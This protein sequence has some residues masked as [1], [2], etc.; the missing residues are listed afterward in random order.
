M[1]ADSKETIDEL[2]DVAERLFAARGVEHVKLTEIVASSSQK[3]RSALH[4]H[5]GSREGVL[6]AVLDRQLMRVTTLRLAILDDTA[7]DEPD[8]AK[9]IYA[10]VAPLCSVVLNEPWG[11][12]YI[13]ILAQVGAHPCLLGKRILDDESMTALRRCRRLMDLSSP[14]IPSAV[15]AR[16]FR[17]FHDGFIV[18]L[19]RWARTTPRSQWKPAVM[20][21][22]IEEFVQYGVAGLSVP[23]LPLAQTTTQNGRKR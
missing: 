22:L 6:T 5:F 1:R 13:S 7:A 3:N 21:D 14:E 20:Q 15:L 4:Y 10:F 8:M 12:D 18:A 17:W 19:A 23:R 16:R 2:L 9:A 11:S